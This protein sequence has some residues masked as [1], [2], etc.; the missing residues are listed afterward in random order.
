MDKRRDNGKATRFKAGNGGG[1]G[2]PV[3]SKS[4]AKLICEQTRDGAE[5]VTI[6]VTIARAGD[7]SNKDK[8]A[9]VGWLADRGFGKVAQPIEGTGA[10]GA[11]VVRWRDRDEA[12]A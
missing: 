6:M 12:R 5:L 3:G 1:P 11:I 10:D 9:A 8:I 4:L 7:A 2:R